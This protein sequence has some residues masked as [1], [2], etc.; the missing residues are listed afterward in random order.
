MHREQPNSTQRPSLGPKAPPPRLKCLLLYTQQAEAS[1][2]CNGFQP[3]GRSRRKVDCLVDRDKPLGDT[4]RRY[5]GTSGSTNRGKAY[6]YRWNPQSRKRYASHDVGTCPYLLALE[7]NRLARPSTIHP[8]RENVWEKAHYLSGMV[9]EQYLACNLFDQMNKQFSTPDGHQVH[10][11]N[12]QS[13]SCG[14]VLE[15]VEAA[16]LCLS[17][18]FSRTAQLPGRS[19]FAKKR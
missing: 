19:A 18:L 2:P 9:T 16:F 7:R 14:V 3:K 5:G 4:Q 15:D 1:K 8:S 12:S 6:K 10:H 11:T 13:P 17:L